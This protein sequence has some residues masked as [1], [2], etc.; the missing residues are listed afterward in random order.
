ME[1]SNKIVLQ[2]QRLINGEY[3][4]IN[5]PLIQFNKVTTLGL[6]SLDPMKV[7][8]LF[9]NNYIHI[10]S[11]YNPNSESISSYLDLKQANIVTNQT[12]PNDLDNTPVLNTIELTAR[13]GPFSPNDIIRE[14]GIGNNG[15]DLYTYTYLK[16]HKN[17]PLSLKMYG[18]DYLY[19]T[20]YYQTKNFAYLPN[21]VSIEGNGIQ[22]NTKVCFYRVQDS[23][24]RG[25]YYFNSQSDFNTSNWENNFQSFYRENKKNNLY[26][27]DSGNKNFND[28]TIAGISEGISNLSKLPSYQKLRDNSSY[29]HEYSWDTENKN[30][31]RYIVG[32]RLAS[33][34]MMI[35]N[36]PII[37][38]FLHGLI[39]EDILPFEFSEFEFIDYK[40]WV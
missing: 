23:N 4:D 40:T 6:N 28:I 9:P 20:Y 13:F 34:Y 18:G 11:G 7:L 27:V 29:I 22:P 5:S 16:N 10:G 15:N 1:Y 39:L 35:F 32:V 37:I 38:N 19:V 30:E 36:R 26:S 25:Y 17:E 2:R 21:N 33:N 3:K 8:P 24:T 31:Y 12:N 14:I